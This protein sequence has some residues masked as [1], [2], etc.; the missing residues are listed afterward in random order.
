MKVEIT[1]KAFRVKKFAR[2]ANEKGFKLYN[3]WGLGLWI[4]RR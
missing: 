4:I 1:R 3:L 2:I